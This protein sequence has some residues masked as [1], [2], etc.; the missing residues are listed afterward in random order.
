VVGLPASLSCATTY[1]WEYWDWLDVFDGDKAA[2]TLPE[3]KGEHIDFDFAIELESRFRLVLPP[4]LS[5]SIISN[6]S[7]S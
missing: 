5:L 7:G 1:S 4:A 3:I 2:T 6:E